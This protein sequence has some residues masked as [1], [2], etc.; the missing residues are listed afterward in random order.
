MSFYTD[1]IQKSPVFHAGWCI[2]DE[3]LLEPVTRAAVAAMMAASAAAG[4]PLMIFETYRSQER[5]AALYA[6][7]ATQLATVGVHHYG[8]ACDLVKDIQGEPSWNGDFSF[9]R[10]LAQAHGLIWGG[11]WGDST[12]RHTF[13]DNV[14]V[15]RVNVADQAK[16]F[17]GDWYPDDDYRPAW[18]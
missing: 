11:N 3:N 1:V 18:K 12:V 4:Q 2:D 16:L 17:A 9:M 8:L 14:H 6:R 7:K 15:Q 10:D 5:Q 13:V